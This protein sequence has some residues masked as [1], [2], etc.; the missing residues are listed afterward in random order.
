MALRPPQYRADAS[1]FLV[2]ESDDAWDRERIAAEREKM[3]AA[4]L[5]TKHHP[6]A[7]YLGGWTRYDLDADATLFDQ[8][9]RVR[10]YLD[11]SKKPTIW[12]LRR[13]GREEWYEVQALFEGSRARGEPR[14]IRCNARCCEL[15]LAGVEN[16]PTLE[17]T[18]GRPTRGD[19]DRIFAISQDLQLDIGQAVY[20]FS[21]PLDVAGAE[22]KPSG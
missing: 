12:K 3:L 11:E 15:G 6:V 19:L 13:L 9:V 2:H 1:G 8:S 16:G 17:L 14:P 20:Q 21:M 10:E 22:G 18:G 7:R 4:G 5:E